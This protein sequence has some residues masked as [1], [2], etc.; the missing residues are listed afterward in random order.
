[1]SVSLPALCLSYHGPNKTQ[2]QGRQND[3]SDRSEIGTGVKSAETV[4]PGLIQSNFQ[5]K[6]PKTLRQLLKK[7]QCIRT[8]LKCAAKVSS[9]REPPPHALSEPVIS[10]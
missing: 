9:A 10:C 6:F 8:V 4:Y 1:M 5:V 2:S 3:A 7:G